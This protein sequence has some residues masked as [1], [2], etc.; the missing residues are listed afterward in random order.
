[1]TR[2]EGWQIRQAVERAMMEAGVHPANPIDV[3]QRLK[4]ERALE[5]H[6][7]DFVDVMVC[8]ECTAVCEEGEPD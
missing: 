7:A 4:F 2:F 3:L 8:S 1:M 6:M 5:Q